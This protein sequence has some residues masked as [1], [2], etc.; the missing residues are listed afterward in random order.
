MQGVGVA[1]K[2]TKKTTKKAAKKAATKKKAS[3]ST[4]SASAK[5]SPAK[6][7]AASKTT[8][9][10]ATKKA[11]TRKAAKKTAAK[12]VAKKAA[13]KAT[14]KKAPAKKAEAAKAPAAAKKTSKKTTK[15]AAAKSAPAKAPAKAETKPTAGDDKKDGKPVR[16]GI[17]IVNDKPKRRS[18]PKKP[19]AKFPP[20]GPRLLGPDSP[21]RRPLIPSAPRDGKA[22]KEAT[23]PAK[24]KKTKLSA[25]QL[26]EYRERLLIKRAQ[27]LGDL[28]EL[29]AEALRSD[30]GGASSLPQHL[31]EQGSDSADQ[32]MSL[33]LAEADRRLI[34]EI[35]DALQRIADKTFGMCEL[36]G[37]PIPK[38][39]LEELPWARYTIQAAEQMERG[40]PR[41]GP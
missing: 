36:T 9:K 4:K 5:S 31:A 21:L 26:E 11:V 23:A 41:F 32:T 30:K 38:A 34:R 2:T 28:T 1:K 14:S 39:R 25:A 15:K 18:A 37:K 40:Q 20:A 8:K 12:K 16:K 24:P 3:G 17:T 7:A 19:V 33:N 6:K 29:E 22:T 27:L 10:A 35:D 13:S